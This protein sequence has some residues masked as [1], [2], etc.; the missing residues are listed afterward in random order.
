MSKCRFV[1]GF[2]TKIILKLFKTGIKKESQNTKITPKGL[3]VIDGYH[4]AIWALI[5]ANWRRGHLVTFRP[6]RESDAVT[7]NC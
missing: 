4:G 7:Q 1:I 2:H 5:I 3:Y 6:S